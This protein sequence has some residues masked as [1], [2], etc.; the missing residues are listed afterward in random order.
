MKKSSLT[1]PAYQPLRTLYQPIIDI[2]SNQVFGYEALTR[3]HGKFRFPGDLFRFS[4]EAGCT[5]ELD[6]DCFKAAFRILPQLTPEQYLFVNVEPITLND[7]FVKGD[8]VD[9]LLKK[10]GGC[11]KQI[12]F[13]LTE[14]MKARDFRY[15]QR[16]VRFLR[17]HGCRFAIDDVAGIGSKLFLLFSLK[18]DFLKIDISLVRG[19][20]KN[21]LQQGL[22]HRVLELGEEI[23]SLVVAEGVEQ[24]K[25]L[26]FIRGLGIPYVQGFYFG[27]PK[28]TLFKF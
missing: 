2:R 3:G 19:I 5:P 22:L 12:V 13:E 20:W 11:R 25:D 6:Y 7:F 15:V 16:A 18:P 8:I 24:K 9:L 4:Y 14:G 10:M 26:D 21:K 17:K 28:K 23:G 27:R 1:K